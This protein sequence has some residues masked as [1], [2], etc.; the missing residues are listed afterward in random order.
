MCVPATVA[1]TNQEVAHLQHAFER[2]APAGCV[3]LPQFEAVLRALGFGSLPTARMFELFDENGNGVVECVCAVPL[4]RPTM[5]ASS[6]WLSLGRYKEFLVGLSTLKGYDEHSLRMCFNIYDS[7]NSGGIT[8]DEFAT[9]MQIIASEDYH[10][11]LS[12][13]GHLAAAFE[14]MDTNRDSVI[15]FEGAQA[16]TRHRNEASPPGASC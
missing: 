5:L 6:Q 15:S 7:D 16:V 12:H 3:T 14:R 10:M 2:R 4:I 13:A 1:V 9:V 8:F 11:E